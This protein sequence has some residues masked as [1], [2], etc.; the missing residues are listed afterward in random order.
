MY[1]MAYGTPPVARAV[2]G[3]LN[4]VEQYAEGQDKG[5]GLLFWEP[6]VNALYYTIGWACATY[7]DRPEEYRGLQIRGMEKDFSW[8]NS[9]QK[10]EKVYQWACEKKGSPKGVK[11]E[12]PAVLV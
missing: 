8:K 2:G 5:T 6:S 4:S 3:I 9:A 11:T 12:Q 10:Y 7:Y 1:S